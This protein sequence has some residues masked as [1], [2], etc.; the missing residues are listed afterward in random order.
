VHLYVCVCENVQ[1]VCLTF[2]VISKSNGLLC[3]TV[4]GI[5]HKHDVSF[6]GKT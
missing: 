3:E 2:S 6:A 1:G 5:D 4:I